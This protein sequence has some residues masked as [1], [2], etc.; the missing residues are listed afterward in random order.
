MTIAFRHTLLAAIAWLALAPAAQAQTADWK[1]TW[2]QTLAAA[3][4]EGKVVIIGQPSPAMRNEVIPA[5]TKR[6]GI[7]VEYISGPSSQLIGKIRTER[8]SGIYSIDVF[9]SNGS[10]AINVQYAEKM[11]DPLK[12]LLLLPE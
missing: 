5:F 1:K 6:F 11:L 12:P 9:L 4:A 2:D 10:T 8:Q 3:K 7:Q